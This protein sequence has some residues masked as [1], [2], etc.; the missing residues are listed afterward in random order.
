MLQF[1][2]EPRMAGKHTPQQNHLLGALAGYAYRLLGERFDEFHHHGELQ[3]L[4][5]RYTQALITQMTQTAVCN[6]YHSIEQQLCRWLLL[7]LERL[8]NNRMIMTQELMAGSPA[9]SRNFSRRSRPRRRPASRGGHEDRNTVSSAAW[10]RPK[11]ARVILRD[12]VN[13]TLGFEQLARMTDTPS[14]SLHRM[15]SPKG[16]PSMDNLAAIFGA[17]GSRLKVGLK[18]QT[19]RAA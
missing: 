1:C 15:L 19:I 10:H 2:E 5:L 11:T 14:K 9:K 6:R 13:A 16:N 17:I 7:C 4:L 8:P 12:L 18:V 3:V